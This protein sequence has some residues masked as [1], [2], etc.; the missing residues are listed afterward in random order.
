[1]STIFAVRFSSGEVLKIARRIG[2]GEG[3]V[4]FSWLN[5]Y[6]EI[7]DPQLPVI[8]LDNS[9]QGIYK[10]ADIQEAIRKAKRDNMLSCPFCGGDAIFLYSPSMYT[11]RAECRFC[12]ATGP[13]S[14]DE[15]VAIDK[16][17]GRDN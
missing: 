1:M 17:N 3:E 6:H 9:P 12:K 13:V 14:S 2:V 7:L 10:V 8:P 11:Y 4:E 16:W 5:H 15:R